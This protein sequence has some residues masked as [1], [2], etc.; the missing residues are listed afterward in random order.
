MSEL[1]FEFIEEYPFFIAYITT[2]IISVA[3]IWDRKNLIRV[4]RRL[5]DLSEDRGVLIQQQQREIEKLKDQ[6]S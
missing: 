6:L 5:L 2:L 3:M 4:G 1:L